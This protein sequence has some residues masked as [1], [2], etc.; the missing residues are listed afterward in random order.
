MNLWLQGGRDNWESHLHTAIFKMDNQQR[1]VVQHVSLLSL[2]AWVGLWGRM[3]TCICMAESLH[4]SPKVTT[5]L[6]IGHTPLQNVLVLNKNKYIPKKK[7][8]RR[9]LLPLVST[10]LISIHVGPSSLLQLLLL[11]KLFI[12]TALTGIQTYLSLTRVTPES[13][14]LWIQGGAYETGFYKPSKKNLLIQ[15][16]IANSC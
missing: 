5:T 3:N 9:S 8:K 12:L 16:R 6:L 14:F 4:C 1:P 15:G 7:K 11:N 13:L 2:P 10:K